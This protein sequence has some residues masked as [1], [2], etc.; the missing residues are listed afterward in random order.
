MAT[1]APLPTTAAE[2]K[3]LEKQITKEA[4]AEAKQVQHTLKDVSATGKAAQKAQKSVTKAEKQNEKLANQEVASAKALNKATHHHENIVNDL[5]SSERDVKACKPRS[6]RRF[7]I[8]RGFFTQ[9]KHQ[10]DAKLSA[11]L[12][13][14]KGQAK[15]LQETQRAHDAAREAKIQEMREA[16]QVAGAQ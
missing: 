13:A 1:T 16:A 8:N 4:K 15:Q 5:T 10:Q 14:K 3:H 11:E 2:L 12:E 9:L 7:P 6:W